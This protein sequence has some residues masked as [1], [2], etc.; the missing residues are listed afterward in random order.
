MVLSLKIVGYYEHNNFGDDQYKLSMN[1]L[2]STYLNGQ[3]Y[4]IEFLD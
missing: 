4:E 1:K 3:D 2:F